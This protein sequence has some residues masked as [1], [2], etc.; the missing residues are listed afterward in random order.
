[1]RSE[2][3]GLQISLDVEGRR[4]LVLGGDDEAADKVQRLLDGGAIVTVVAPS[5][6]GTIEGLARM[7]K[8]TLLQRAFFPADVRDAD[9][10]LVC[11]RDPELAKRVH[12]AASSDGAAIWCVDDPERSDFAMPALARAGKMRFAI[13]SSGGS[14]ALAARFRAALE[15]DLGQP[16]REFVDAVA[17][18]RARIKN[19]VTDEETR[20]EILREMVDKLEIA[21]SVKLPEK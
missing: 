11:A 12:E 9:V 4:A 10:V 2:A 7:S 6:N 14:P 15:R 20:R 1:M 16:F 19:E 21:V 3:V 18:A 8:L 13:S 17:A 5:V